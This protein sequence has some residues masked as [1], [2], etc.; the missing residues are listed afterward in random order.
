M[1]HAHQGIMPG[2][3]GVLDPTLQKYM[4]QQRMQQIFQT[5]ARV[6]ASADLF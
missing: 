1:P 6:G 2:S 5:L 3:G 4:Q